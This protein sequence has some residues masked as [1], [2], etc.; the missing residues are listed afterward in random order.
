MRKTILYFAA[1]LLITA[2][3]GITPEEYAKQQAKAFT[4]KNCPSPVKN[5]I[6]TDSL[7][8]EENTRTLH[9]YYSLFGALDN[10]D[11]LKGRGDGM[12]DRMLQSLKK[13][14]NMDEFKKA[15]MNFKYTYHSSSKPD[16]VLFEAV[17]RPSEYNK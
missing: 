6:R 15:E 14:G 7:V 4:E 8:F 2:C 16:T 17:F 12:R 9:Y 5:D 3:T 11:S 1:G 13:A 10:P